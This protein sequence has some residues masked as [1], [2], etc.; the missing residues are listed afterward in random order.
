MVTRRFRVH[1]RR[2]R[3]S[4]TGRHAVGLGISVGWWPC[5][6]SPYLKLDVASHKLAFWFGPPSYRD[7]L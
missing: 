6:G 1:H 7:D 3:K 4:L 5:Y 2:T